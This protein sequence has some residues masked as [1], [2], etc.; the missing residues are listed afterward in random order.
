M[1]LDFSVSDSGVA[2]IRLNNPNSLNAMSTHDADDLVEALSNAESQARAIV[3]GATGKS[4][5]AGADF[6]SA[7]DG[8]EEMEVDVKGI[9]KTHFDPL[10]LKLRDL[11]VPLITEV[12]GAAAG[13]GCSIAIMGDLIVASEEAYFLQAF[14]NIGLVP[15][16]ASSYTLSRAIGRSRAMEMMLLGEKLGAYKAL[17]FGLINRVVERDSL[18]RETF[19]LANRLAVGATKGLGLIRTQAWAALDNTMEEQLELE[20]RNQCIAAATQDHKEGV[21]A[22]VERRQAIFTGA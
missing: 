1:A 7:K 3:L 5:C 15:D 17:E 8:D 12:R 10:I 4:F 16:G 19:E 11:R 21:A 6:S 14:S 20:S 22:F 18:E 2:T 9:L 13:V